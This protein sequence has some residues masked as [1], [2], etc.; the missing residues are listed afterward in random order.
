MKNTK[1]CLLA[2]AVTTAGLFAFK[3]FTTGT[4]KGTVAPPEGGVRAW[5]LSATDTFRADV[6]KGAFEISNVKAGTYKLIVEAAPPYKNTAKDGIEV[7]D[8][9]TTDVGEIKLSQ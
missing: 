3:P 7:T 1:L 6:S 9:G 4:V 8:G 5:V 2:I